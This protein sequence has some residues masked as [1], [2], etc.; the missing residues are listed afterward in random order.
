MTSIPFPPVI[1]ARSAA[2]ALASGQNKNRKKGDYSIDDIASYR[3]PDGT[4]RPAYNLYQPTFPEGAEPGVGRL[5][6]KLNH[7]P[8]DTSGY[9]L[10]VSEF[11]P[12]QT[13]MKDC[14]AW[15]NPAIAVIDGMDGVRFIMAPSEDLLSVDYEVAEGNVIRPFV[16]VV[17]IPDGAEPECLM[18]IGSPYYQQILVGSTE[19][20]VALV[21][22]KAGKADDLAIDNRMASN[23]CRGFT[24]AEAHLCELTH[25]M[26]EKMAYDFI[27][28]STDANTR[29][30][31][32]V[33]ELDIATAMEP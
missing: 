7:Y 29:I 24:R 20:V 18:F 19:D 16:E 8:N 25:R 5:H 13:I 2:A 9:T 15:E 11:C 21:E 3:L 14:S 26:R 12:S 30:V 6:C 31:P 1:A 23:E 32:H 22:L 17:S 33:H 4:V 10:S 27:A 28:M